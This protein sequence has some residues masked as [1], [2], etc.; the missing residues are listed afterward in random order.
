M[1]QPRL[2]EDKLPSKLSVT[3]SSQINK[4]INAIEVYNQNNAE[5]LS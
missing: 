4:D 1:K 2:C 5:A 3:V